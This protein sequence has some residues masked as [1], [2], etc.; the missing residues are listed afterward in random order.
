MNDELI[1]EQLRLEEQTRDSGVARF[2]STLQ[3]NREKGNEQATHYGSH[4]LRRIIYPLRA[5]IDAELAAFNAGKAGPRSKF[6]KLLSGFPT[7]VTAFITARCVIQHLVMGSPL[8][9]TAREIASEIQNEMM[10]REFEEQ[11]PGLYYHLL[12]AYTVSG[13]EHKMTVI[14]RA[15]LATAEDPQARWSQTDAT[16]LGVKLIHL[17]I[18]ATGVVHLEYDLGERVKKAGAV[19]KTVAKITATPNLLEWIHGTEEAASL[20]HPPALPM[21]CPPQPWTD[22]FTGGYLSMDRR[23]FRLVR[24]VDARTLQ[25]FNNRRADMPQV[26]EAVNLAQNTAW[27]V[28]ERVLEV[29][30]HI[31]DRKVDIAGIPTGEPRIVAPSPYAHRD[32]ADLTAEELHGLRLWKATA[33]EVHSFNA[34]SRSRRLAGGQALA[35]ATQFS[36]YDS[37]WFP[38]NYDFRGRLYAIPTGLSPQ[39]S[40]LGKG[41]LEFAS[42][43]PIGEGT[44]PGWLAVHGANTWGN[45]KVTFEDRI[46]WVEEH[47]DRILS[48]AA[49]PLGD[50]WWT[51]ADS[52]FCFLSFCFEWAGYCR[53]GADHITRLPVALDGSCSGLQHYS[54]VLLDPVGAAA[55]NLTPTEKPA[56]VYAEVASRALQLLQIKADLGGDNADLARAL[57]AFGVDRK[58]TKRPT[59]TLP[60]GST[61]LSCG[62][63]VAEWLIKKAATLPPEENPIHGREGDAS[64]VLA[65]AI[66]D[67]IGDVVQSAR[68]AM[69]WL[70]KVATATTKESMPITW[71]TPDGFVVSQSYMDSTH[72]RVK[73]RMGDRLVYLS[74]AELTDKLDKTRQANGFPPNWVHSMDATHLRSTTCSAALNGI[75][76]IAL[77]HD[78]YG[79]LACDIDVLGA[80]LREEMIALYSE[81]RLAELR[82]EVCAYLLESEK[83]PYPP[84]RG[85]LDLTLIRGAQ[86][87]FA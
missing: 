19:Q 9:R 52:P 69:S 76:S 23:T 4:V 25:E 14:R 8:Q 72:R 44:G 87:T 16:H 48:C 39:G 33:R 43:K 65:S 15:Y 12:R 46:D 82:A 78:S 64:G 59:M 38:H 3:R 63:Y 79:A 45:D 29:A 1:K 51:E 28:N 6:F 60:Y 40:D 58:A 54:A 86:F 70:R 53:D 20:L 47:A 32:K 7:D 80:V 42:G 22:A 21:V 83:V 56:D 18:E 49:D 61:R 5:A 2:Y 26:Y 37:I 27:R 84:S 13:Q 75:E 68:C 55:V 10:M 24:G 41:L 35:V 67:A 74:M 11:N 81:D 73:T 66:W 30:R 77:I 50:L 85:S 31:W 62:Q 71:T 34:Q 57:I 36:K 17:L